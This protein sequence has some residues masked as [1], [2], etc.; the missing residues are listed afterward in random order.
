MMMTLL[1]GLAVPWGLFLLALT[2]TLSSVDPSQ[3]PDLWRLRA[4]IG[5][6]AIALTPIILTGGIDLSVG[7][8]V[9]LSGVVMGLVHRDLGWSI[10]AAVV[11]G[12]GTGLLA[13][14]LNGLL[15]SSGISPLVATLATM[16]LFRGL[17]MAL[18]N[19]ER[20]APLPSE[21][22]DWGWASWWGLPTQIYLLVAT[23]LFFY[24]FVH[25][26]IWGRSIFAMG[27]NRLAAT[28]AAVPVRRI[29]ACLYVLSGLAAG[30]VAM[31]QTAYQAAAVP[32]AA[33]GFE[34][35]AIACVVLGGTRVTGGF[36]SI[37][38]TILGLATLAHLQIG[39]S[40]NS[41]RE[42]AIPGWSK[43]FR[44]DAEAQLIIIGLLVILVAVVNERLSASRQKT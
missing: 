12:I 33:R 31:M 16:A 42:W 8:M 28:F 2:L 6:L 11:S 3:L 14:G 17:A 44:L 41:Q 43:P 34:L 4:D 30:L 27:E 25:H 36:G 19:G 22:T 35:Q 39:L 9:A 21:L 20:I 5:T 13:G 29:E 32:D 23:A 7:S 1:R 24:V 10:H 26:T 38:R 15:V 40:L 18:V 37:A